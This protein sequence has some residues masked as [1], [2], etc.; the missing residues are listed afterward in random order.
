MRLLVSFAA[1]LTAMAFFAASSPA[2]ADGI[3]RPRPVHNARPHRAPPPAPIPLLAPAEDKGPETVTLS[4]SFVSGANGGVGA[5]IGGFYGGGGTF[6]VTSGGARAIAVA[7]TS[8][9]ASA[10]AGVHF[11]RHGGGCG[12]H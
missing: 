12:C 7:F 8:A 3:E 1:V 5:D 2:R 6:V 4:Q 9:R 10:G 11:G